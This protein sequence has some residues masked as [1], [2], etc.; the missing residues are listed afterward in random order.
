MN[1]TKN[2]SDF[3]EKIDGRQYRTILNGLLV[4]SL[5]SLTACQ[6]VPTTPNNPGVCDP[7]PPR[8]QWSADSDGGIY[9]PPQS[10]AELVN[11]IHDLKECSNQ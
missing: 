5:V 9:L 6:A 2:E 1:T 4:I 11:Y 8:L 7:T 3:A 10:A